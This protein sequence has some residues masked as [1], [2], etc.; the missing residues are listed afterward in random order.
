MPSYPYAGFVE[1]AAGCLSHG[2]AW[3]WHPEKAHTVLV[4]HSWPP[5]DRQASTWSRGNYCITS[6]CPACRTAE[7]VLADADL[8]WAITTA[9][10]AHRG[11]Q[12]ECR[13]GLLA[14]GGVGRTERS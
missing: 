7:R 13:A 6:A 5:A 12:A 2:W 4:L 9:L 8:A 1:V 11:P 14:A 3:L 10:L